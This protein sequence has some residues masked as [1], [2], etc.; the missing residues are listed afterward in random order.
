[1]PNMLARAVSAEVFFWSGTS[2][3]KHINDSTKVFAKQNITSTPHGIFTVPST[4][5]KN[6]SIL[7][8]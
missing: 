1:M 7:E 3:Y 4:S 8:F 2:G 6:A 5:S